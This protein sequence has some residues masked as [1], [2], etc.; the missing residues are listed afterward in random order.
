V[1]TTTL[2]KDLIDE[3]QKVIDALLQD[4]FEATAAFW[5]KNA[6]DGLWRFYV[7]S[8]IVETES[9]A[10]GYLRLHTTIR[11]LGLEWIDPLEVK[12]IG[13]K[14]PMAHDIL[15]IHQQY[16]GTKGK[17]VRWTGTQ[18]GNRNVEGAYL[19]PLA[20]VAAP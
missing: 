1:D 9:P 18:L 14:N 13:P 2:V 19:Y 4:G 12:L 15:A 7:V 10:A 17:S 20:A 16:G 3:G 6:E 8:P 11:R 5:L